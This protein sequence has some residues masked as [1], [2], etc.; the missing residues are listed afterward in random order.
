M[1]TNGSLGF[2]W[3]MNSSEPAKGAGA[4]GKLSRQLGLFGT[5]MAVMGGIVGAGI[6]I[7]P[8]IVAERVQTAPLILGAW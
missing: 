6:F 3:S 8:Y 5:T 4:R 7:N 1:P 2:R